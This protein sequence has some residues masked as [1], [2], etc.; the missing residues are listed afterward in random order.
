MKNRTPNAENDIEAGSVSRLRI[1]DELAEQLGAPQVL[2]IG[3][4]AEFLR[5]S[6]SHV[7]NLLAG[8]VAGAAPLP[9]IP[10]GR[11]K[12]IRRDSL[13]RWMERGEAKQC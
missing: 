10:L 4:V 13:V 3:D 6:K 7:Q 1:P 2:T 12:L 5:C 9:F 11:R 8:K